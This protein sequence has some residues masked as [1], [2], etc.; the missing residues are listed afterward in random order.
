MF[1]GGIVWFYRVLA[2]MNIDPAQPGYRHIIFKPQPAGNVTYT[3]YSNET[4]Y[5]RAAIHW[6]KNS[7]AFNVEVN[8]PVGTTATV[9]VPASKAESVTEGG[10]KIK[11]DNVI[12][13]ERMENGYAIFKVGAGNF[14]FNAPL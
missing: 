1:G 2:G 12:H 5:G 13:F 8:V 14:S 6:R 10:K 3:S 7:N 9:Y 4:P 11:D